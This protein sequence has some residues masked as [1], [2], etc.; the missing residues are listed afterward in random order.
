MTNSYEL[1]AHTVF[2]SY[3]ISILRFFPLFHLH[4]KRGP[5]R[6]LSVDCVFLGTYSF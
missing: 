4:S 6:E 1:K 5:K 2:Q 3:E